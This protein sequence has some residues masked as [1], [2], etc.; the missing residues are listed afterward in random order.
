M[1]FETASTKKNKKKTKTYFKCDA[2][3][4]DIWLWLARRPLEGDLAQSWPLYPAMW[5]S[6]G[7]EEQ[8]GGLE[9]EAE[10]STVSL[11]YFFTMSLTKTSMHNPIIQCHTQMCEVKYTTKKWLNKCKV[12]EVQLQWLY[13][14]PRIYRHFKDQPSLMSLQ[15]IP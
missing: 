12:T 13:L 11:I 5:H 8:E 14:R 2:H 3:Q 9:L 10:T 6:A 1:Q 4:T 15:V 7:A